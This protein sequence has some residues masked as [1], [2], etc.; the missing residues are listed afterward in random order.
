MAKIAVEKS[1]G[2]VLDAWG[3]GYQLSFKSDGLHVSL[4]DQLKVVVLW[5]TESE[6]SIW[7]SIT[8]LPEDFKSYKYKHDGT[9]WS[10]NSDWEEDTSQPNSPEEPN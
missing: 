9:N 5:I 8:G 7:D 10:L 2:I 1:T 3:D 4:H 6:C